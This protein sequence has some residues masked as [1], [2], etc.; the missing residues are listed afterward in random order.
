MNGVTASL[1]KVYR[2]AE[3]IIVVFIFTT[4]FTCSVVNS[5]SGKVAPES[6]ADLA[7]KLLP[8]VVNIAT[9][10]KIEGRDRPT[11]PKLPPGSPFEEFFKD[12]FVSRKMPDEIKYHF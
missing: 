9:T 12:F 10:Q 2:A 5:A 11:M 6:F 7:E 4:L 1:S 3:C 8:S